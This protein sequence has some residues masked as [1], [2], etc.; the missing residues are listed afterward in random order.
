MTRFDSS[1]SAITYSTYLGGLYFDY[2][3]G[4]DVDDSG[5]AYVT[6][7]CNSTFPTTGDGFDRVVTGSND[8]FF[9]TLSPDG[10]SLT[11]STFIGGTGSDIGQ[12]IVVDASGNAY[13]VG[14]SNSSDWATV[15]G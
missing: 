7:F 15:N 4:V 6:G 14:S 2:V 1:G 13:V 8:G 10:G 11:Y 12:S 5:V 9:A 3:I